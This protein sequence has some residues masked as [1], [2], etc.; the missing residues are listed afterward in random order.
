MS[1]I[2]VRVVLDEN[3]AGE[4]ERWKVVVAGFGRLGAIRRIAGRVEMHADY[5]DSGWAPIEGGVAAAVG[6]VIAASP[7]D[8]FEFE[9]LEDADI[10]LDFL[11]SGLRKGM[12]RSQQA[13]AIVQGRDTLDYVVQDLAGLSWDGL[14]ILDYGCGT[15]FTQA[16]HQFPRPIA[17][18]W[19]VDIDHEMIAELES[20]VT[21]ERFQ[22]G[23]VDFANEHYNELNNRMTVDST[24]PI[25]P[26]GSADLITMQSVMTHFFPEDFENCLKMLR[27][28]LAPGGGI[29]FTFIAS[30]AQEEPFKSLDP[31]EPLLRASYSEDHALE[32]IASAGFEIVEYKRRRE[33]IYLPEHALVRPAG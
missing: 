33:H 32:L 15:K 22:F 10:V 31:V 27:K 6:A 1:A 17:N 20:M 25:P 21:D 9:H 23:T 28:Y 16:L 29:F 26:E 14:R 13:R 8:L 7:D 19:G 3:F 4:G 5:G 2:A 24:L 12:L 18:Y 11:P 30:R